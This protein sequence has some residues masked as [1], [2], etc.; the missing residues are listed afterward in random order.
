MISS[1]L[2]GSMSSPSSTKLV[3]P[4]SNRWKLQKLEMR[5]SHCSPRLMR[6]REVWEPQWQ[7]WKVW[8]PRMNSFECC[9]R[10]TLLPQASCQHRK[11][12]QWWESCVPFWNVSFRHL[13]HRFLW[14]LCLHF[15]HVSD[16]SAIVSRSMWKLLGTEL[17]SHEKIRSRDD[18]GFVK[19]VFWTFESTTYLAKLM[20]QGQFL[21]FGANLVRRCVVKIAGTPRDLPETL[22]A[23]RLARDGSGTERS[24]SLQDMFD[25]QQRQGSGATS[26]TTR[27]SS[28]GSS[29]EQMMLAL[30]RP[31]RLM[32]VCVEAGNTDR[33]SYERQCAQFLQSLQGHTTEQFFSAMIESVLSV[34]KSFEVRKTKRREVRISD[35]FAVFM[36]CFETG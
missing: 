23:A 13:E 24:S 17:G 18:S 32:N 27:G 4:T 7:D 14:T 34:R 35:A 20:Q 9:V 1:Q 5:W 15:W 16:R 36:V 6:W 10:S 3:V 21:Q 2:P 25:R 22:A 33:A 12:M 26:P 30:V 29:E 19:V 11:T 8:N 28:A 31:G